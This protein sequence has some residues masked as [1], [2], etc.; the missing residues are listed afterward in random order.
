[1]K[2][3][4]DLSVTSARH[5][6]SGPALSLDFVNGVHKRY[7]TRVPLSTVLSLTRA[8]SA[9]RIT[10]AGLL[11]TVP[12]DTLRLDHHFGTGTPRGALFEPAATNLIS[13]SQ[14][15]GQPA[16]Q[17]YAAKPVFTSGQIAPDGSTTAIRWN[18]AETLGGAGG[19]RGGI[20]VVNGSISGPVTTSLWIKASAPLTMQFGQSD[21]TSRQIAVTTAWQRFSY[22]GV[23]PNVQNRIC[24]LYEDTN[25]NI[26]VSVW[27]AQ[28]EIG[29]EAST[30]VPTSGTP[31]M[32]AA[33][34]AGLSGLSGRHDVTLTYDDDSTEH[35]PAQ[36]ITPGWW[37]VLSRCWLKKLVV[38]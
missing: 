29:T 37:P 4:C 17:G 6:A 2:L 11:E 16:W 13:H 21:G 30:L 5:H 22:T 12:A 31:A 15:F 28:V 34:V 9:M 7:G 20:L 1:M 10:A 23:L 36:A 35:L 33:D 32:R 38:R 26:D 27:G 14:D 8:T 24:M 18:C 19:K 25:D 3:V